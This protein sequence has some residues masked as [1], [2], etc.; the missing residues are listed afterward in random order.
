MVVILTAQLF[1]AMNA[2]HL[3][4]HKMAQ[5][6]MKFAETELTTTQITTV[7]METPE[8]MMVVQVL[9]Q[10]REDLL[11]TI[12]LLPPGTSVTKSVVM[13]MTTGDINA[14]METVTKMTVAHQLVKSMRVGNVLVEIDLLQTHALKFVVME[15]STLVLMLQHA[16][17][18]TQIAMMVAHQAVKSNMDTNVL[19]ETTTLLTIVM[20]FVVTVSDLTL[21]IPIVMMTT[22]MMEMDAIATVS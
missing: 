15:E 14:M 10:L 16:M 7:M 8:V 13:D 3:M 9:A 6:V 21:K 4:T 11:A 5:I 22:P 20:K 2:S 1:L 12:L 18:V 19:M 17:M